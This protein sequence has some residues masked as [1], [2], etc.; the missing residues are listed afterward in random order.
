MAFKFVNFDFKQFIEP[1]LVVN[2]KQDFLGSDCSWSGI[3]LQDNNKI[4]FDR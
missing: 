1:I 3:D 4:M 2:H